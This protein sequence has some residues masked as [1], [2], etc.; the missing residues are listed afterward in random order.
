MTAEAVP[1]RSLETTAA[2]TVPSGF[3]DARTLEDGLEIAADVCVVGSGA[4]GTTLALRLRERGRAVLLLESGGFRPDPVTSSMT[5]VDAPMLPIGPESRQRF[6]GGTTN[7]WWG[8]AAMLED[9]DFAPRS[10]VGATGWP[11]D[12]AEL[13]PH[14]AEG[15]RILGVPDLTTTP[16]ERFEGGRGFLV[17]TPE[18]DTVTLYWPRHPRRFRQLLMPAVRAGRGI[19]SLLFANVTR[20]VATPSGTAVD[21]LEVGTI[22]G[23]RLRVRPRA[24]VL[25][26]GGIEN[27]RLLLASRLPGPASRDA[28]GRYYMDHAKGVVGEIRIDPGVRRLIHPAYWDARPGRFRLGIRLSDERQRREELLDSYVRFHPVLEGA[29]TG[30]AALRELRRHRLGALRNPRVLGGLVGGLPEIVALGVFKTLNV[31]RVR[32]VE[33]HTFM[34]LE[35]RPENRVVLSDRTDPFGMPLARVHWTVGDLDRRTVRR[36]HSALDEDL[37]RRGFGSVSSPLLPAEDGPWP[38]ARDASHHTGTTRMGAD[39]TTSVVD[40]DCRVHGIENL[41]V[42]GSSVFPTSGYANPT[43]TIVALALRLGDHLRTG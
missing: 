19:E 43:L 9:I 42:A 29:G 35:P 27:A 28:V 41:Y 31:G 21:H 14:Y 23:R 12:R 2:G 30:A 18:L 11:I 25:A 10:W 16:L 15:C 13:L 5:D 24:V 39:P 34:E 20:V 33:I 38:I 26:C 40:R 37:R 17:R 36:L 32:A 1:A 6:L 8:G 3:V 4:A 7:T 22:N